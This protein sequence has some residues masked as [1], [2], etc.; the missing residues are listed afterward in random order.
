MH[1][2]LPEPQP[3]PAPVVNVAGP[4]VHNH[5]PEPQPQPAPVVNVAGPTVHNHLPEQPAPDVHVHNEVQAAAVQ[6]VEITAMPTRETT[7]RI[8]RD[9][10]DNILKT[11]QTEQDA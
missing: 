3:Q 11:T 1:N 4:T 10:K 5:L 8:E 6:K 2:H 9:G 7:T